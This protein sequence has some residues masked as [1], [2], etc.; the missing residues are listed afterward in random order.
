LPDQYG[1]P[2]PLLDAL[3]PHHWRWAL[4]RCP[5]I[6][7]AGLAYQRAVHWSPTII[8]STVAWRWLASIGEGPLKADA[9][10]RTVGALRGGARTNTTSIITLIWMGKMP[11]LDGLPGG[12]INTREREGAPIVTPSSSPLTADH[13]RRSPTLFGGRHE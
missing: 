2:V 8:W 10:W 11:E 3:S 12:E 4:S 7:N 6:V 9:R 13:R 5:A 1:K